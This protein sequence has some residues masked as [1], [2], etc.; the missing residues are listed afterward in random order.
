MQKLFWLSL[1]IIAVFG[2]SMGL[3]NR[4]ARRH[5]A[6]LR[7]TLDAADALETEIRAART[8]LQS[9]TSATTRAEDALDTA[10]RDLLKQRLWLQSN[11]A[12][13]STQSLERVLDGLQT[14]TRQMRLFSAR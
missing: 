7:A 14:A 13:A 2:L 3:K 6:T 5:Q 1:A 10:M 12:S 9:A 4:R 8:A 11:A